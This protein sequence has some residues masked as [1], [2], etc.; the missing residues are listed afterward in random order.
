MSIYEAVFVRRSVRRFQMN[1]VRPDILDGVRRFIRSIP[2]L[3]TASRVEFEIYDCLNASDEVVGHEEAVKQ[4]PNVRLTQKEKIRGLW[5]VEAP[6]YLAVYCEEG[7]LGARNAGYMAEQA[8]LYLTSKEIGTCYLGE[9]KV[10]EAERNGLKR[11]VVIAF[12]LA[13]GKLHRDSSLAH[14]LSLAGLC[15]FKDEP[16]EQVKAILKAARLAPSSFNSQ[17]WRFVVYA[18]RIYIFARKGTL[19]Q[20]KRLRAIRDF[21]MGIMLSHI[22]L[23]A[24]EYWMN[25]ET[26]T[27]EQFLKKAYK[28][29]AYIC[30][31]IFHN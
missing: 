10:G 29:G 2:P 12:G 26:V 5:K 17:P 28:N 1:P 24:E 14:R 13:D 19:P 7:S 23:A 11:L 20:T 16:G 8:V 9:T 4:I 18:D 3:D 27:E 6:Y 30:T 25:L 21:N 22:M 15:A 31:V